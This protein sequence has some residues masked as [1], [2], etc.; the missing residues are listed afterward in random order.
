[1]Y[2][3]KIEN[4]EIIKYQVC[5]DEETLKK[6]RS[7][8]IERCSL[9]KH[10]KQ[11]TVSLPNKYDYEHIRNYSEKFI[12]KV[13]KDDF[14]G[15][16]YDEYLVEYD[17]YEHP[18]LVSLIDRLIKG[19]TK[20]IGE[21]ENYKIDNI[22]YE[23]ILLEEQKEIINKLSDIDSKKISE[24]IELLN[25][26]QEKLLNYQNQKILNKSQISVNDYILSVLSCIKQTK[27]ISIPLNYI[28]N[29]QTFFQDINNININNELN[30]VLKLNK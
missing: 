11:V 21:I 26:N 24:Q 28:I 17:Y 29:V 5:L 15:T 2:F 20:V 25:I 14:Y 4:D 10:I 13:D 8:I 3:Y 30:K 16:V 22:D 1:M 9:I 6:L 23:Q 19:E 18:L 12:R 27:I 7:E